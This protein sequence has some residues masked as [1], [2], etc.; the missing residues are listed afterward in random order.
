MSDLLAGEHVLH[1][2]RQRQVDERQ[3]LEQSFAELDSEQKRS[4]ERLNAAQ[5][6]F[7]AA[8]KAIEL[9]RRYRGS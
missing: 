7:D 9:N 2:I 5:R 1:R 6:A 8:T 4:E 3:M